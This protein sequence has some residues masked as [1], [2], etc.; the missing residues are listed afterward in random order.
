MGVPWSKVVVSS[1]RLLKSNRASRGASLPIKVLKTEIFSI[2]QKDLVARPGDFGADFRARALPA[3]LF[4]ANDYVQA[5]SEHR[6]M[7]AEMAPIYRQF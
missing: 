2:H 1:L 7:V 3:V 6:R 4:T 5:T